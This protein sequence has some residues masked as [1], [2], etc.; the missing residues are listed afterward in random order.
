MGEYGTPRCCRV[1]SLANV[2]PW[3]HPAYGWRQYPIMPSLTTMVRNG[4]D[5]NANTANRSGESRRR[6]GC[7][8]SS[9]VESYESALALRTSSS[10]R[11]ST[12]AT[13]LSNLL[14][15]NQTNR[16]NQAA[17]A[18]SKTAH[19]RNPVVP[20]HLSPISTLSKPV[21]SKLAPIAHHPQMKSEKGID[22]A[23]ATR[24]GRTV[25]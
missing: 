11:T 14:L 6:G 3:T 18:H 20:H 24:T 16:P 25:F 19:I 4:K 17:S 15:L 9:W 13:V 1:W 2:D 10:E 7:E 12:T 23:V 5:V 21:V 22:T 8:R